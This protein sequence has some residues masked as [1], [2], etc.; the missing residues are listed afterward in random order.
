VNQFTL[1]P[2][3]AALSL[4]VFVW[5]L[6]IFWQRCSKRIADTQ[7]PGHAEEVRQ[8]KIELR[9]MRSAFADILRKRKHSDVFMQVVTD[10]NAARLEKVF[11][12]MAQD[13]RE[14][15]VRIFPPGWFLIELADSFLSRKTMERVVRA[16]VSDM[17]VEYFTALSEK[18]NLRAVCVRI[19]GYWSFW[20]ALLLCA[21]H[22]K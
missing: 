13:I 19:R 3:V 15:Q 16:V 9:K 11:G 6:R 21:G 7:P 22:N 8:S 14:T 10:A 18:R 20:K 1:V 17:Q 4:I 5:F 12:L 2:L